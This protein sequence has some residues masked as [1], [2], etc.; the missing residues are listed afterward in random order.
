MS[1]CAS[2]S[3][4]SPPGCFLNEEIGGQRS[5]VTQLSHTANLDPTKP[6]CSFQTLHSCL[7]FL[8]FFLKTLVFIFQISQLPGKAVH[9]VW[10]SAF[11]K[12]AKCSAEALA[13]V[14]QM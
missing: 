11:I 1:T 4:G 7:C 9:V 14:T 12:G 10:C 2:V 3:A 8:L 5:E 6:E 13:H